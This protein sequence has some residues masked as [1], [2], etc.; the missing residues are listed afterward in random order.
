MRDAPIL[1]PPAATVNGT[2]DSRKQIRRAP[3]RRQAYNSLK[4]E[5]D[6]AIAAAAPA[7]DVTVTTQRIDSAF[8]I[9]ARG[10]PAS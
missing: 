9:R 5:I 4:A 7:N 2:C 6:A 10:D 1:L 8:G 3:L